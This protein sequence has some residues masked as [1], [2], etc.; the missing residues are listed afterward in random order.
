MEK[1]AEG[2]RSIAASENSIRAKTATEGT[3]NATS[4]IT[5]LERVVERQTTTIADREEGNTKLAVPEAECR[6]RNGKD[7]CP[8]KRR[9][10]QGTSR[11]DAGQATESVRRDHVTEQHAATST[12]LR[13]E[14]ERPMVENG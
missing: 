1:V 6:L 12:E 14:D 4:K 10:S 7:K 11:R 2:R 3:A 8:E 9:C 5:E 13:I